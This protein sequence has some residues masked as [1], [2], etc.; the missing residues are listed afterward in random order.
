MP[1]NQPRLSNIVRSL[2]FLLLKHI[3]ALSNRRNESFR[4]VALH[5]KLR[6][7]KRQTGQ[8]EKKKKKKTKEEKKKLS[9]SRLYV[10]FRSFV[11]RS[12]PVCVSY[13]S[14]F[15]TSVIR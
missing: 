9:T 5:V 3:C 8:D 7:T 1:T 10:V 14:S 2:L 13:V 12:S 11:G 4:V 15:Y 6:R